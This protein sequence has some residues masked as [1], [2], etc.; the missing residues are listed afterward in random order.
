[1]SL[2]QREPHTLQVPL[3]FPP[4]R[5]CFGELNLSL[6]EMSATIKVSPI[7]GIML[8]KGFACLFEAGLG[9][10][11]GCHMCHPGMTQ[12]R[13][14]CQ[15]IF[16]PFPFTVLSYWADS[17]K[18]GWVFDYSKLIFYKNGAYNILL[19]DF[20]LL[21]EWLPV[22]V[23]VS[24]FIIHHVV[25]GECVC[26]SETG[27]GLLPAHYSLAVCA[28]AREWAVCSGLTDCFSVVGTLITAPVLSQA[29]ASLPPSFPPA[30][31]CSRLQACPAL[32]Q[33]GAREEKKIGK[34]IKRQDIK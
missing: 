34:L 8:L 19:A 33:H 1:M 7:G 27:P 28:C 26:V 25:W 23:V 16:P 30:M 31:R 14:E 15:K 6:T 9:N 21:S 17:P 2:R 18:P 4:L 5:P 13:G 29:S 32:V 11:L 12:N 20:I 3:V 24:L 10:T 22:M